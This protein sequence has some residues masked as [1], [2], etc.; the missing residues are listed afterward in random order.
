MNTP[1]PVQCRCRNAR[2]T[3]AIN[4][5]ESNANQRQRVERRTRHANTDANNLPSLRRDHRC[6]RRYCSAGGTATMMN[7]S[8]HAA[9]CVFAPG[10]D[11][12][13][14]KGVLLGTLSRSEPL[15]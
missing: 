7:H 12:F 10:V 9:G 2:A 14:H 5:N 6:Q 3:P 11:G 1:M 8:D 4:A 15:V 13:Y